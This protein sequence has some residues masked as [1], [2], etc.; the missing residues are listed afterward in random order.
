MKK[1]TKLNL[2]E[3]AAEMQN[4]DSESARSAI[5]GDYYYAPDGQHLG[6]VGTGDAVRGK[7]I[8]DIVLDLN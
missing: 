4:I 1:M 3:L 5:G 2:E 8:I 7:L 6:H